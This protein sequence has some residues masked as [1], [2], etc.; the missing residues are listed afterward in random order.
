M[1][2]R[3]KSKHVEVQFVSNQDVGREIISIKDT[4]V[5][6]IGNALQ[7]RRKRKQ[8]KS[9]DSD[10]EVD[11]LPCKDLDTN[12][13]PTALFEEGD[14]PGQQMFGFQ[15]TKGKRALTPRT[16][17]TPKTPQPEKVNGTPQ[18]RKVKGTPQSRKVNG[19]PRASSHDTGTAKTPYSLR[20]RLKKQIAKTASQAT[21]GY[22]SDSDFSASNSEYMP[23]DTDRSSSSEDESVEDKDETMK[24]PEYQPR[25]KQ[26]HQEIEYVLEADEF[27]T[28]QKSVT[29]DH[30]LSRL[31][32]PRLAE[33]QLQ[34]LLGDMT[35]SHKQAVYNLCAEHTQLFAKWMFSL[36]EQYSVLLYGLGSKRHTLHQFR[37]KMLQDQLVL[38]VNGF[39][40]SL[41][42]KEIVDSIADDLLEL[43]ERPGGM[44]ECLD[45]IE[46]Q[47][48][49]ELFIIIHNLDGPMLQSNKNQDIIARLAKMEHIHLVASI[50]HINAPL[51]EFLFYFNFKIVAR[52]VCL[53]VLLVSFW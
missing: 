33:K 28:S 12:E 34:Q 51:S 18:S 8:C 52:S 16:P 39:F 26:G 25:R 50:D 45:I 23:S 38:E 31:Q 19:R 11:D 46:Q 32:Q 47:L 6:K 4:K 27:F 35:L 5:K 37:T 20:R 17:R 15:T 22:L 42:I 43:S 1:E 24:E 21:D 40:P 7:R 10:E 3:K 41:T 13:R 29:S 44:L 9:S 30:T 49:S 36:R 53:P 2:T 48:S 14:V